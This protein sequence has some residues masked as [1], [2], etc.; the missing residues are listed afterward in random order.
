[1]MRNE[2][3]QSSPNRH[4]IVTESSPNR[5][6]SVTYNIILWCDRFK[7]YYIYNKYEADFKKR[8]RHRFVTDSSLSL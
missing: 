3:T 6:R 4:R 7:L 1:M 2:K 5:H 8:N